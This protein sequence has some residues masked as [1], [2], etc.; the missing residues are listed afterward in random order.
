M[1]PR[2][3]AMRIGMK[4]W[5]ELLRDEWEERAAIIEYDGGETRDA[6]EWQAF[7]QINGR[8]SAASEPRRDD[9]GRKLAHQ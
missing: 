5:T 4:R 6:A 2:Q 7:V 9:I 3:S 1:T 8:V